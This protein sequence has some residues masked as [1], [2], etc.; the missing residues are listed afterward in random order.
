MHTRTLTPGSLILII[1]LYIVPIQPAS[2]QQITQDRDE[3]IE[4]NVRALLSQMSVR[5]KVGQMT[6]VDLNVILEGGYDNTDGTIDH[7]RLDSAVNIYFVGSIFNVTNNA[8]DLETW[9]RIITTIQDAAMKTPNSIPVIYGVDAIHG[10]S[11]VL[12]STLFPHNIGLAATRNPEIVFRAA[13]ITAAETRASGVRWNFDPVLDIGRNPLWARFEETFGEDP[14][15]TAIMSTETVRGYQG[16]DLTGD[17]AVGATLK[18]YLGYSNPRTGRDRTPAYVPEIEYREYEI[19]QYKAAID[20]G[21]VSV[22][23]N[24]GD[25]NGV[26]VHANRYLLTDLLR[27]E[28]GF[29]GVVVSDWQ[30]VNRLYER[31][32]IAPTLK[33]AVRIAVLAGVD[34]SMTPHDFRFA[35]LLEEL[36]DEDP[37]IAERVDESVARILRLKFRLGLFDNPYPEEEAVRHFG[38]PEYGPVALEAALQSITLLK[39]DRDRLPLSGN[40]TLLIAGPGADNIPSLHGS[41]SYTW[42]GTNPEFYPETTLSIKDAF[43]SRIGKEN[44]ISLSVSEYRNEANYDIHTLTARA[45][46]ADHIVLCLGEDAYAESPG[47][48][49]DLTLDRRQ[50]DLAKAAVATG[51]PV[52]VILVSGRPRIIR[53]FAD[54]VD[55][56]ILAYRPGSQGAQA[57]ADVV[58]GNYNPGGKLPFTYP[59]YPNDLVLYDHRWTELNVQDEQGDYGDEGYNPQFPFGHG[60]SYTTFEYSDFILDRDVIGDHDTLRVSVRVRNTGDRAGSE[61]VELYSRQMY[62]SVVPPVRRLRKFQ[63]IVLEP[64]EATDILFHLTVRDLAYTRYGTERGTFVRGLEE[65]EIQFMIN[66]F[67]FDLVE[68]GDTPIYISR[69]FKHSGSVHYRKKYNR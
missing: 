18:H 50:I 7:A 56:I 13:E 32:N 22:M 2:A 53:D 12:N 29:E 34:M 41:W 15:I 25:L 3:A 61:V 51:K 33:D 60:L 21:A 5:E 31:H 27:D 16:D 24:S 20:A 39:N 62:A 47:S 40:E 35:E 36:Y 64:G 11:Y 38:L 1:I 59:R 57:I 10:A 46:G 49:R 26:P 28:L 30:D 45:A 19:P 4:E 55:A 43:E 37:A 58:F 42:M 23:V 9:H 52:T 69:P 8:Y 67:G 65:G 63:R 54:E 68:P 6:Q 48:I 44:I 14:L 66:G 17:R